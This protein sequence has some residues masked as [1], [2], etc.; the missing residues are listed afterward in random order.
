MYCTDIFLPNLEDV[1]N[2]VDMTS[3]YKSL[4]INLVSDKYVI[5]AHSIIGIISLDITKPIALKI[6]SED[7]PQSF[8]VDIEPNIYKKRL[9][10]RYFSVS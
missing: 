1:K 4:P 10:Q 9:K 3:K 6:D 5:D 7:V 2:F 8:L